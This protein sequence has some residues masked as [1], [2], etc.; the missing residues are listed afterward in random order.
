MS[1]GAKLENNTWVRGNTRFISS[2]EHISQMS[3]ANERHIILF[4]LYFP[5]KW[6]TFLFF[7]VGLTCLHS[8]NYG[9]AWESR[10]IYWTCGITMLFHYFYFQLNLIPLF[11]FH[12]WSRKWGCQFFHSLFY[13]CDNSFIYTAWNTH[14]KRSFD[15][16]VELLQFLL[17]YTLRRKDH[18]WMQNVKQAYTVSE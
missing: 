14:I 12:C 13:Y 2:V 15:S 16:H 3:A 7:V 1:F 17:A 6:K 10:Q 5:Q 4:L 8:V 11:K 9:D 18:E